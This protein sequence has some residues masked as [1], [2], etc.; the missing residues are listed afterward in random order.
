MKNMV[1]YKVHGIA[2]YVK[3]NNIMAGLHLFRRNRLKEIVHGHHWIG[4]EKVC[5]TGVSTLAVYSSDLYMYAS[6]QLPC[7]LSDFASFGK[8]F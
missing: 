4:K 1:L 8:I 3:V 7:K 2:M 6:L 5:I